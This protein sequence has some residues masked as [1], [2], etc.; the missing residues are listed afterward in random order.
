MKTTLIFIAATVAGLFIATPGPALAKHG[1]YSAAHCI[2][3]SEGTSMGSSFHSLMGGLND[4]TGLTSTV[5]HGWRS[6]NF[7]DFGY[8]LVCPIVDSN[9]FEH[10]EIKTLNVHGKAATTSSL[11][12]KA[13]YTDWNADSGG[14][15]APQNGNSGS[16]SSISFTHASGVFTNAGAGAQ[17]FVYLFVN[18]VQVSGT[19]TLLRGYYTQDT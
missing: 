18:L 8:Y 12:A 15:T 14:C 2:V 1:R 9:S 7:N 3:S 19:P 16:N 17:D 10:G 4:S 6:Q 5:N 13:C 11:Q